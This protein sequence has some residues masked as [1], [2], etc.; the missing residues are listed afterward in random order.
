MRLTQA[1]NRVLL[2]GIDSSPFIYFVEKHPKYFD[3]MKTILSLNA[4]GDFDS[5]G[6]V[7]LLTELLTQPLKLENEYFLAEYEDILKRAKGF[8]LVNVNSNIARK[9]AYLRATYNLRTPDALHVA[10]AI[11]S[12]CDAFLTNDVG[13]KRVTELRILLLDELELDSPDEDP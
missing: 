6:S 4:K 12:G 8:K 5:I 3:L 2:V 10:T 7:L 1:F 11:E 13:I 9:A